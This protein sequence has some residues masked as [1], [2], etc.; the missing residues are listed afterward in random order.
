VSESAE[1]KL[2]DV[3]AQLAP[4]SYVCVGSLS[5]RIIDEAIDFT[6]ITY[7]VALDYG[8]KAITLPVLPRAL[9]STDRPVV[10][11]ELT[12]VAAIMRL[13]GFTL[14]VA[15]SPSSPSSPIRRLN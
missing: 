2:C 11:A 15:G 8:Q 5:V 7:H 6:T 1:T 10:L 12:D 13:P 14:Y 3:W 4:G 9:T